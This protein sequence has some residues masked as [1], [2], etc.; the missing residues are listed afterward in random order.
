MIDP[1]LIFKEV[2]FFGFIIWLI[3]KFGANS[4]LYTAATEHGRE[5][6]DLLMI[7]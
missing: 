5:I 2:L 1:F 4:G 7:D 3:A 6:D